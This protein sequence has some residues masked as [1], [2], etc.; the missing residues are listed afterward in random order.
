MLIILFLYS[1]RRMNL[2]SMK[3]IRR[4]KRNSDDSEETPGIPDS[5]D[6]PDNNFYILSSFNKE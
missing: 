5:A 2:F 6:L 1:F 4:H 3:N